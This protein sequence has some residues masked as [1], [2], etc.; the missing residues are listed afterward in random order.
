[1]NK[2]QEKS[3]FLDRKNAAIEIPHGGVLTCEDGRK[4]KIRLWRPTVKKDSC[5]IIEMEVLVQ[6]PDGDMPE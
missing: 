6:L 3:D 4:F 1:V 5:V 2:P